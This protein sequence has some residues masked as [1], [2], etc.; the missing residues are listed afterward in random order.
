MELLL[1]LFGPESYAKRHWPGTAP[2]L[3]GTHRGVQ[4][5]NQDA[6]DNRDRFER[7]HLLEFVV[8][9]VSSPRAAINIHRITAW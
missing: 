8:G 6:V 2:S 4:V 1:A 7:V 3:G 5:T 9:C